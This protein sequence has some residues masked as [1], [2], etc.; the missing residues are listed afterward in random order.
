[1]FTLFVIGIGLLTVAAVFWCDICEWF[2][3]HASPWLTKHVP[4]LAP[5]LR[6]AFQF[7]D[8]NV[9]SP[10]RRLIVKAW[11][12]VRPHVIQAEVAFEKVG[13]R[14]I[15]RVRSF[16]QDKLGDDAQIVQRTEETPVSW[17]D[18]PESVRAAALERRKAAT[19]DFVKTR[20]QEVHAM[21]V[22]T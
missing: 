11:K 5:H 12:H 1:M 20:D 3:D 6:K 16:L 4:T 17:E 2:A 18:L 10:T 19:V 15:R 8:N 13:G 7:I 21:Q 22:S 14:W 9:G